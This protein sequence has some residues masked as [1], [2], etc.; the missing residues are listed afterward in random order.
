MLMALAVIAG[1]ALFGAVAGWLLWWSAQ[2]PLLWNFAVAIL[3][4]ILTLLAAVGIGWL[5]VRSRPA[6]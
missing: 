4:G 2:R 6:L 5:M 1:A 3:L